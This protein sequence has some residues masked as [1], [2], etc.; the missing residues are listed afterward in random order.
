MGFGFRDDGEDLDFFFGDVIEHSDV[1]DPKVILR[2]G[3]SAKAL[4]PALGHL[5]RLE[6]QVRF[7][8]LADGCAVVSW[9]RGSDLFAADDSFNAP[10]G[11]ERAGSIGLDVKDRDGRNASFKLIQLFESLTE[12]P[13]VQQFTKHNRSALQR[14]CV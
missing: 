8:R 10:I 14:D 7:E 1:V 12:K 11:V 5:R 6:A 9:E 2:P 4:D 3:Q 13:R